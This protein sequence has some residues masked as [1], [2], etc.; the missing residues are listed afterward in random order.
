MHKKAQE[1][2]IEQKE[3][4]RN[5]KGVVEM[6]HIFASHELGSPTKLFAKLT[7]KPGCSI[8]W[9]LH[10]Q[11][12]E[13]YYILKGRCL[14]NDNGEIAEYGPGDAVVTGGGHGHSVE[15]VGDEAM[16]MI[17]VILPFA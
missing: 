7:L 4:L 12:E 16:E 1:M 11:E 14:V 10:E 9:H 6:M 8:G 3:A 13:I 15:C 2:L 5:G 17:A